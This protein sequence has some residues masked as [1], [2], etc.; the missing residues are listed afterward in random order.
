MT[1][2]TAIVLVLLLY[3]IYC[4]IL[5]YMHRVEAFILL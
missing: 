2:V 1:N 4:W 3:L 5:Y